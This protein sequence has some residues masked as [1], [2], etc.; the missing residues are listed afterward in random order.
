MMIITT[1]CV[2]VCCTNK[3]AGILKMKMN[4]VQN[5]CIQ[6]STIKQSNTTQNTKN[7]AAQEIKNSLVHFYFQMIQTMQCRI[8]LRSCDECFAMTTHLYV[9]PCIRVFFCLYGDDDDDD[10]RG[11]IPICDVRFYFYLVV[12]EEKN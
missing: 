11:C 6:Q 7:A 9:H 1:P 2:C 5:V 8:V 4:V 12:E 3:C 10:E